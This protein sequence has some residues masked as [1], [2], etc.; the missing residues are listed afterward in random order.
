[1]DHTVVTD[2]TRVSE[3]ENVKVYVRARPCADGSEPFD[4]MF[5]RRKETPKNITIKDVDKSQYGEHAFSFDNI[6]WTQTNQEEVFESTS[7]PLVEF[8]L[9]G[10]NSC[11]FAYGQTGSG[12]TFSIFGETGEKDGIIPRCTDHLFEMIE[13]NQQSDRTNKPEITLVVSFLEIYCDR[14]RDLGREYAQKTGRVVSYQQSSSADWYLRQKAMKRTDSSASVFSNHSCKDDMR[15]DYEKENLEIHEDAQGQVFVKDLSMIEVTRREEVNVMVQMGLKLRSTHETKMNAVSSRSHTVFSIHVFQHDLATNEVISGTLNM[16]DLAGSERLKKSESDGQRLK[17]ALHINSSLSAVGKVVMSLDPESRFNYIPYRD[18][19]L[20]RLLQ[21]SIGG[22]SFTILIATI[23][24]M[25]EHYEECLSTMQFANRCRTVQNQ[26]RVNYIN[27]N[28]VDKDRRIRKL[29][30]EIALL[31]RKLECLRAEQNNRMGTILRELGYDV[32]GF[33]EEGNDGTVVVATEETIL[34]MHG[35]PITL[36][37]TED[38]Q[39]HSPSKRKN[40][41]RTTVATKSFGAPSV[42]TRFLRK[43]RDYMRQKAEDVKNAV[44]LAQA[45]LKKEKDDMLRQLQQQKREV[46]RLESELVLKDEALVRIQAQG[47]SKHKEDIQHILEHS[48]ALQRTSQ[49]PSEKQELL[50]LTKQWTHHSATDRETIETL[51]DE[52]AQLYVYTTRLFQ[53]SQL[54]LQRKGHDVAWPKPLLTNTTKLRHFRALLGSD[55]LVQARVQ[56]AKEHKVMSARAAATARPVSAPARRPMSAGYASTF[57]GRILQ[58]PPIATTTTEGDGILNED[59]DSDSELNMLPIETLRQ[60]LRD[61][62]AKQQKSRQPEVDDD[63]VEQLRTK[64]Q[65]EVTTTR[66]QKNRELRAANAALQ[67]QQTKTTQEKVVIAK[68]RPQSATKRP[69]GREE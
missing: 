22:N 16:V 21:N 12:K 19:K 6:F 65:H 35:N 57:R 2:Y 61:E 53:A 14:L 56:H 58:P 18:S 41:S 23:H 43:E 7:K 4:G 48:Q 10:I 60:L 54:H 30:D 32:S 51:K 67:R 15:I 17:E 63:V 9:K 50:D 46:L 29:Q 26:P 69:M 25:K 31:K 3:C 24:P 42:S 38:A 55:P 62:R 66:A 28:V 8:A 27:Q 68:P 37:K 34:D 36:S 5:E 44:L 45:E 49:R 64:L 39:G 59:D 47:A 40:H 52:M 20:T 13:R 1:M 33:T 11:C